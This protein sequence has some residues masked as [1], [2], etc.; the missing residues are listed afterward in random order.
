METYSR[1]SEHCAPKDRGKEKQ[2]TLKLVKCLAYV[3][4]T[5]G[6]RGVMKDEATAAG[7]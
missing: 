6:V 1:S 4:F 5:S 2:M 3:D 7:N